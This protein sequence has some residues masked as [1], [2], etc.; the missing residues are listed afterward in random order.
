MT[1]LHVADDSHQSSASDFYYA[2]PTIVGTFFEGD[3]VN[4]IIQFQ[5]Q[6]EDEL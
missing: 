5:Q 2:P 1:S 3:L 6:F 4:H